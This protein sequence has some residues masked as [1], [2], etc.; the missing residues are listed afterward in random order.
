VP[1]GPFTGDPAFGAACEFAVTRTIR[2]AA[3]LLDA[4][5]GPGIGDK[6]TAPP[7]FRRYAKEIGAPQRALRIP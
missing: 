7:P 4:V 2:D 6:Y 3:H 1:C 5:R